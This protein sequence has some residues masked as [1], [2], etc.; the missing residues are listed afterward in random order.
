MTTY[1]TYNR[2][3]RRK[4]IVGRGFV[5]FVRSIPSAIG[6]LFSRLPSGIHEGIQKTLVPA[7]TTAAVAGLS[8]LGSTA[9]N[10]VVS[11]I[12]RRIED[13]GEPKIPREI[14]NK[15]DEKSKQFLETVKSV[16]QSMLAIPQPTV[17]SINSRISG[18]GIRKTRK[19]KVIGSG[20][21]SC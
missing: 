16:P 17:D 21:K 11:V 5:D 18:M 12:K 3:T 9:I 14:A 13:K 2:N 4:Y 7:L 6:G 10:K 20:I 15:L 19:R 1:R 8:T